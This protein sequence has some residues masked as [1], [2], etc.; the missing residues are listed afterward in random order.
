MG[1]VVGA[2]GRQGLLFRLMYQA[3][4]VHVRLLFRRVT[5]ERSH[6]HVS[7]ERP[8]PQCAVLWACTR[9]APPLSRRVTLP[10]PTSSRTP[11]LRWEGELVGACA[12][13]EGGGRATV[14]RLVRAPAAPAAAIQLALAC[15][16]QLQLHVAGGA[17]KEKCRCEAIWT[18]S[19]L[20]LNFRLWR[21]GRER[22]NRKYH[23]NRP[24]GVPANRL[25]DT[26][27]WS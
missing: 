20:H 3:L 6:H 25:F 23:I 4:E 17:K 19:Y 1:A 12:H 16:F 7:P 24:W 13:S 5:H 8:L 11:G 27:R 14:V 22:E 18:G 21:P 9:F 26:C 10:R 15:L 2:R